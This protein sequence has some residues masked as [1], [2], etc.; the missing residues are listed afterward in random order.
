MVKKYALLIGIN[1]MG[2]T[3]QL[4]GCINDVNNM[5]NILVD[6]FGYSANCITLMTDHSPLRPTRSNILN[7]L[8][9]M[10]N[11]SFSRR[12]QEPVEEIWIHYSGH[13]SYIRDTSGDENDGQDE[14]I[15]PLDYS[16]S[17]FIT[18]DE[19]NRILQAINPKV[20]LI[21]LFDSCH[22]GTILDLRYKYDLVNKRCN[23][24]NKTN[25]INCAAICISG[26]KDNQTSADAYGLDNNSS[27]SGAMTSSFLHALKVTNYTGSISQIVLLMRDY[28]K[29]N[30]FTQIPQLTCSFL[31]DYNTRFDNFSLPTTTVPPP[32]PIIVSSPVQTN[33][34][35]TT[36]TP[37]LLTSVPTHLQQ[38]ITQSGIPANL[39]YYG[40]T[41]GAVK[42]PCLIM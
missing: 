26:C 20:R 4:S 36:V 28:L 2:T 3:S 6:K 10:V 29:Q 31:L 9:Q 18:D 30:G 17:G 27:F 41:Q 32:V 1:Y 13:G 34:T 37:S 16:T 15:C 22:S 12:N 11:L 39:Y 21:T 25:K 40:G 7:Q 42:P 24:D 38:P 33:L 5:K 14:T 35:P 23:E 8:N 19:L